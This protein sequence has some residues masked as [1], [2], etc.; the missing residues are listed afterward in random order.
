MNTTRPYRQSARAESRARTRER[1]LE[2][3][4]SLYRR[5][6][7]DHVTLRDVA[8]EADVA[9]QT[10]VNHFS[11]KAGLLAAV[12]ERMGARIANKRDEVPRGDAAGGVAM[13]IGEY[14]ELGDAIVRMVALEDRVE[15]LVP[16]LA[17]GRE[18]HRAWVQRV[19]AEAIPRSPQVERKRVT[20]G[21]IAAT[22]VLTWKIL[23]RE[24][25]LSRRAA[26]MAMRDLVDALVHQQKGTI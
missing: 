8:S 2:G 5:D 6:W 26:E 1:I 9:I 3:A 22:D 12:A 18:V 15:E 13:L 16:L 7:Y 11:T 19:F 14:E 24:Q 20:A 21:F 25:G 10:V 23:R 4:E 17:H